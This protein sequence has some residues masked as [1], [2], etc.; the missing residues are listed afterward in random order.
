MSQ[1][2]IPIP[3]D[4]PQIATGTPYAPAAFAFVQNGLGYTNELV[5]SKVANEYELDEFER[6]VNGQQLFMGL[7]DCAIHWFGLLAPV[8]L[9]HWGIHRTEDFGAI[10]FKMVSLELLRTSPQDCE[11]D[12]RSVFQFDDAFHHSE[13]ADRI[14]SNL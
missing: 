10:V 12:F 11:D 7:R 5:A 1:I 8:V 4:W 13:L 3:F 9:R 14:G 2:T 6:H